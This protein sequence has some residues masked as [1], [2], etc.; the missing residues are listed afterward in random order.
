MRPCT[1]LLQTKS[2]KIAFSVEAEDMH[3]RVCEKQQEWQ[4]DQDI[5]AIPHYEGAVYL[6]VPILSS[7]DKY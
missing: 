3:T 1:P 7:S 2:C 5:A 6:T 4:G